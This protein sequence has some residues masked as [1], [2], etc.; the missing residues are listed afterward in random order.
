MLQ[1]LHQ[2][3]GRRYIESQGLRFLFLSGISDYDVASVKDS[4][5]LIFGEMD[6]IEISQLLKEIRRERDKSVYLKPVFSVHQ[7]KYHNQERF[8]GFTD[9]TSN[10]SIVQE[11]QKILTRIEEVNTSIVP[12][13]YEKQVLFKQMAFLYTRGRVLEPVPS[14][15]SRIG[16]TFPFMDSLLSGGSSLELLKILN[17]G[18]ENTLLTARLQDRIH[19]C[20]SCHGNYINFREVCP[21]CSSVNIESKD[22]VHHFKCAHVDVID[23][24]KDGDELICPKCD[25]KLRHIGIDYDK[26][27]TMHE[28]HECHHQFQEADMIAF[29]IDCGKEEDTANLRENEIR[30]HALTERGEHLVLNGWEEKA[31]ES[32]PEARHLSN[33]LFRMMLNL[34]VQRAATEARSVFGS[35]EISESIVSVLGEVGREQFQREILGIIGTYID[36]TD[37][38]TAKNTRE[39]YLL[40][41]DKTLQEAHEKCELIE[42]NLTKLIA[43]NINSEQDLVIGRIQPVVSDLHVGDLL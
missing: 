41:H 17:M 5:A 11:A 39:Y 20:N 33:D 23:S 34:E 3:E 36:G 6:G 1:V 31:Q 30:S 37:L 24:F 32:G 10:E 21:K 16:Y 28:C 40:F 15:H 13:D 29:C 4:D 35:F 42:H 43:D 19:T 7:N 38:I 26:P 18:V 2:T 25:N 14:R 12:H 9:L 27:S 22:L 8:D